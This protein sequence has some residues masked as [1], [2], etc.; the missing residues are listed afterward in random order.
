[1]IRHALVP[2][3]VATVVLSAC[4]GEA[5]PSD[6]GLVARAGGQ[7]WTV[8]EAAALIAPDSALPPE[9]EAVRA[10][11]NLWIDYTLLAR[12]AMADTTMAQV[13]V[14]PLVNDLAVQQLVTAL[15]DSV[16]P[17]EPIGDEELRTRYRSEASGTMVRARQILLTFP[18]DA[19][20]AKK[21]S[22]RQAIRDLRARIVDGKEDF[23]TLAAEHSQ[24][25]GG[26][27]GGWDLGVVPRGLLDAS[28]DSVLFSL[29][30]GEVSR[31]V[32]SPYGVHL[33]Q[34]LER[35]TPSLD[36]FRAGLMNRR[37]ARAESVY[38]AGL[39][40][41]ASPR[42]LE[43]AEARVRQMAR[44]YRTPLPEREETRPLVTYAGGSVTAGEVLWYLQTQSPLVRA[45][46]A[47]SRDSA[48]ADQVLRAVTNR[49][50]LAMEALRRGWSSPQEARDR[51]AAAARRNLTEAARQ[52]G[53]LHVDIAPDQRPGDAVHQA[54]SSLLSDMLTGARRE[55]TPLG[56]MSYV[57][58]RQYP[59]HVV[60]AGV[61]EV[62]V[63]IEELRQ[64]SPTP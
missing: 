20:D 12:A 6:E 17:M 39:E 22:V 28:L 49:E 33:L 40:A 64:G 35:V 8:E 43:G 4:G 54:V 62:V 42:I 59:A 48:V 58:R 60:D 23:Q 30:P 37:I 21:D 13:D 38:V 15:R 36:Q 10:I 52:M 50:L 16:V 47:A 14:T 55:V 45:Q 46:V 63:R 19:T 7:T 9:P 5:Q 29:Q 57:L 27:P 1:M 2:V 34:V 53:L 11:A 44:N 24:Q 32:E 25:P 41:Q 31:P 18:E 51:A 3:A 26:A 61:D 56:V